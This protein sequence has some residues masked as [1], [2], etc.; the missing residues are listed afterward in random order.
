ME[1]IVGVFPVSMASCHSVLLEVDASFF[2]CEV[3]RYRSQT[4]NPEDSKLQSFS[5]HW[6]ILNIRQGLVP[7][8][9]AI[10]SY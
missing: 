10:Y 7:K 2:I 9:A 6:N 3:F 4:I 1:E 5:K 8:A